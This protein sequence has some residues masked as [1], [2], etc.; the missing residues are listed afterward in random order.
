MKKQIAVLGL[1]LGLIAGGVGGVVLG[2]PSLS[3]AQ[4]ESTTST[5]PEVESL[6]EPGYWM[7][8]ALEPLVEAGT[9]TQAQAD[10][11][12]EALVAA[13]P[14]R[15]G[16]YLKRLGLGVAAETIGITGEELATALRDGSSI[17]EVATSKGVDPQTVIDA[18]LAELKANLDE[19]VANGRITQEQAD[20]AMADAPTR[21]TERVNDTRPFGWGRHHGGF[22]GLGASEATATSSETSFAF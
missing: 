1:G 11:V 21:I 3:A 13:K 5:A 9:I 19:A 2:V 18:M 22:G 6:R 10:A 4:E 12:V 17:A 8:E 15:G 14:A 7:A 16:H 20:A